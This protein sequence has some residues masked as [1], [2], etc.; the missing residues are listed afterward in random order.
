MQF[1]ASWDKFTWFVTGFVVLILLFISGSSVYEIYKA[2]A[3]ES[4]ISK[5]VLFL[6]VTLLILGVTYYFS[7][8]K[9]VISDSELTVVRPFSN[10]VFS[11]SKIKEVR[12][13][14]DC[15]MKFTIRTF[16]VG[17]LFG[18][19]GKFWN[20]HIKHFTAYSTRLR[21]L[22]LVVTTDDKK[23]VLSPNDTVLFVTELQKKIQ[24]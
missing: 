20:N 1:E 10:V 5:H 2:V 19:V 24:H 18:Y 23:F 12:M 17:G 3:S 22:V 13:L 6:F 15:D 9:Y 11:V 8:K 14:D 16:G 4:S 7:I 21:N